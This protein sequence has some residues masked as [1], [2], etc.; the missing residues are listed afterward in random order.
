MA[1]PDIVQRQIKVSVATPPACNVELLGLDKEDIVHPS[2]AVNAF[3][4]PAAHELFSQEVCATE[5][6]LENNVMALICDWSG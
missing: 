4:P 5:D 3:E 2:L 1:I 6:S